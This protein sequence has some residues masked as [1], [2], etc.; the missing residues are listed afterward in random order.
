MGWSSGTEI[1]TSST[2]VDLAVPE[3]SVLALLGPNG[4]GKTT[5]VRILSTLTRPDGG[6]ARIAGFDVVREP[7]AVR[8]VI[9]LT[10]QF[11][12]VDDRQTGRENLT[13]VARLRHL[14]RGGARRRATN[15]LERFDL[16]EAA[17][18]HVGTWSG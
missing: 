5:T 17:D 18:R 7:F 3:G 8:G 10:G 2:G 4:A 16:G 6:S 13:M 1:A 9:G 11:A 15:L 12:A 14:G